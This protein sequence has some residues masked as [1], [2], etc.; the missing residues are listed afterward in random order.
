MQMVG[1]EIRF[2]DGRQGE[3]DQRPR[4]RPVRSRGRCS[5][6]GRHSPIPALHPS[7]T[8]RRGAGNA[9]EWPRCRRAGAPE[10]P[11]IRPIR[12]RKA[13]VP[14][15]RSRRTRRPTRVRYGCGDRAGLLTAPRPAPGSGHRGTPPRGARAG[16]RR[17]PGR[18]P[19][20][21]SRAGRPRP[22]DARRHDPGAVA[23][24]RRTKH[25]GPA[26]LVRHQDSRRV[27][28]PGAVPRHIWSMP[29]QPLY[30]HQVRQHAD[31]PPGAP[32]DA[33][34]PPLRA[35]VAR[36]RQTV[37]SDARG[38]VLDLARNAQYRAHRREE[39]EQLRRRGGER[40]FRE[41][42]VEH[43]C[44]LEVGLEHRCVQRTVAQSDDLF[45]EHPR[46]MEDPVDGAEALH[47]HRSAPAAWPRGRQRPRRASARRRRAHAG[48]GRAARPFGSFA[49]PCPARPGSTGASGVSGVRPMSASL[50]GPFAARCS[51]MLQR[52]AA[53]ITG[54]DVGTTWPASTPAAWLAAA[55]RGR[56]GES[57]GHRPRSAISPSSR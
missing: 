32:V 45:L 48:A 34:G 10:H 41:D 57:S 5:N 21:R 16:V 36:M 47:G 44:G 2:E 38:R 56:T 35:P 28:R 17:P 29:H 18:T 13:P 43:E 6:V 11:R 9:G 37:E 19:R 53:E 46:G 39:H 31:V 33:E 30:P 52:D 22:S 55:A 25:A 51:A 40:G 54:D 7:P 8:R 15:L 26:I 4:A 20:A 1:I 27:S 14:I 42:V 24:E 50:T 49:E 12:P 23:R 3:R